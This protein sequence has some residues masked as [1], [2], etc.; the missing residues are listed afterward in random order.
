MILISVHC[1]KQLKWRCTDISNYWRYYFQLLHLKLSTQNC[2]WWDVNPWLIHV[3][4]W[5]KPLQYCKVIS[6]QLIKINEKKN[7]NVFLKNNHVS[8]MAG[9]QVF[10]ADAAK[11]GLMPRS[12]WHSIFTDLIF[13]SPTGNKYLLF[14]PFF[15]PPTFIIESFL[16]Q[17]VYYGHNLIPVCVL[18]FELLSNYSGRMSVFLFIHFIHS[19]DTHWIPTLSQAFLTH[20][21]FLHFM[22]V[23]K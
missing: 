19:A 23:R 16:Y 11:W 4:V 5:H 12:I 1:F 13:F 10:W 3:N 8:Y 20:L 21:F 17:E 22:W 14:S 18:S 9:S 15:F 7:K 6:L 2:G